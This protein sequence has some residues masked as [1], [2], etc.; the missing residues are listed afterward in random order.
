MWGEGRGRR[1]G[2]QWGGTG[3]R[4]VSGRTVDKGVGGGKVGKEGGKSGMGD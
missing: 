1:G 2:R 3:R 4:D